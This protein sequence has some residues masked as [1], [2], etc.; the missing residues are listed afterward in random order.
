MIRLASNNQSASVNFPSS[1]KWLN[2]AVCSDN[3]TCSCVPHCLCMS[4]LYAWMCILVYSA[5]TC[6][7]MDAVDFAH[8]LLSRWQQRQLYWDGNY[9][10]NT[11]IL[12]HHIY[13]LT[14]YGVTTGSFCTYRSQCTVALNSNFAIIKTWNCF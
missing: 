2:S 14:A 11:V 1:R 6:F 5:S 13:N 9:S 7:K 3:Y 4:Y 8:T 10:I 12:K